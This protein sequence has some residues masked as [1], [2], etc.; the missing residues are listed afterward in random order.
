MARVFIE[1]GH[2][3]VLHARNERRGE[4]ALVAVPGGRCGDAVT[5]SI[6]Q[7]V[8]SDAP[9]D[10][11]SSPLA[12][13]GVYQSSRLSA[14]PVRKLGNR[15]GPGPVS[16]NRTLRQTPLIPATDSLD[17]LETHPCLAVQIAP[18]VCLPYLISDLPLVPNLC[19]AKRLSGSHPA[20]NC[21]LL[22]YTF[23]REH[24]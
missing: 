10:A 18:P 2:H 5:V 11:Q 4:E 19:T 7:T 23:R 17:C 9:T 20:T 21:P 6:I 15:F 12:I 1:Q 14:Y 22:S 16:D 13:L 24:A 8:T 3:A